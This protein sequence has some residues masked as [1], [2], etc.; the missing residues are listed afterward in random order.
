MSELEELRLAY[1]ECSRQKNELLTQ[2]KQLAAEVERLNKLLALQK[3]SYDRERD[4][5][6]AEVEALRKHM[7][8]IERVACHHG[9]KPMI[10]AA[11]TLSVIQHYPPIKAIT[12]SYVDGVVPTTPDPWA[13]VEALRLA[14]RIFVGA[15]IPCSTEIDP[16]GYWWCEVY[17][18]QALANAAAIDAAL[19]ARPQGEKT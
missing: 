13:E 14:L 18:D 19:A 8:F 6:Q 17:A 5:D 12:R 15:A 16:R 10:T 3:T 1:A 7:K 11:D 9:A 4:A 2:H